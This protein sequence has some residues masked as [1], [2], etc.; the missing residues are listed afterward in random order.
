[1]D[2]LQALTLFSAKLNILMA[3]LDM[4]LDAAGS[5]VGADPGT[6]RRDNY[7][8]LRSSLNECIEAI[9]SR[10]RSLS[11]EKKAGELPAEE[12]RIRK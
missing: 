6:V 8:Q 10:M 2:Q 7:E 9:R 11:E 12:C 5:E 1:M 4:V 3:Q